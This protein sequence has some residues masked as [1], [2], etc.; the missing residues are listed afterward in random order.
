MTG[1]TTEEK[2]LPLDRQIYDLLVTK[3][4]LPAGCRNFTVI[5]EMNE[6]LRIIAEYI[7]KA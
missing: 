3:G 6:P 1:E 2:E 4:Q 7:P 5:A